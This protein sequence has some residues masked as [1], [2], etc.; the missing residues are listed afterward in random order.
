M[1]TLLIS[2]LLMNERLCL[3]Q[4]RIQPKIEGGAA[5]REGA[6][7]ALKNMRAKGVRQFWTPVLEDSLVFYQ[8]SLDL[9][10]S[11]HILIETVKKECLKVTMRG[12][13]L[14]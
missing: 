4:G 10:V 1:M 5:C 9:H 8:I 3:F 7:N 2:L 11:P 6:E 13:L 12:A 14:A